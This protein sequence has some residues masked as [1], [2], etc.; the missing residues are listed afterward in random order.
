M[1]DF[2]AFYKMLAASGYSGPISLHVENEFEA[3]SE[4]AKREKILQASEKD[5]AYLKGQVD[6]AFG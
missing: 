1:V 4:A 6:A 5:F 3:H 2:P